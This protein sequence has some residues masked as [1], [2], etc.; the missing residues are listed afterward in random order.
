MIELTADGGPVA[1]PRDAA[2]VVLL[3]DAD[4]GRFEVLM[5]RRHARSGF[6]ANA[7]VFPGGALDDADAEPAILARVDGRS[8]D[9][10]ASLLGEDDPARALALHVA[11]A[12]ETFEEAGVL[13]ASN[14][15]DLASDAMDDAR[16]RLNDGGSFLAILEE[17]G[18]SI[19]ADALAPW[20][21]WVTPT[22]EKRRYD[23]RF[24]LA[25]APSAQRAA[26]DDRELVS[27]AWWTPEDALAR[28][29]SSE[30]QLP[31]PTIRTLEELV[32]LESIDAA[33][34]RARSRT[35][36]PIQPHLAEADGA[37]VLTL[38]GDPLHPVAERRVMGTS[39]FALVDG[40]FVGR[41][42]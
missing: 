28:Y 1:E 5:M 21:R 34:A 32:E 27:S 10:A 11:A 14:A 9:E 19:T 33:F 20:S 30:I 8:A 35:P 7:H 36:R 40:R 16:A 15:A 22:R 24:F 42:P 17:L 18:A 13:L 23:A 39:R 6:M 38:P 25:R 41:D 26:H 2:T 37:L 31:P 3:R 4:V 12:R 29:A